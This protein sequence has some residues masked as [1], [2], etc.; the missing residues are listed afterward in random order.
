MTP[1]GDHN[2]SL[3]SVPCLNDDIE[4]NFVSPW[5]DNEDLVEISPLGNQVNEWDGSGRE[6]IKVIALSS[7]RDQ[8]KPSTDRMVGKEKSFRV[9]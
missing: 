4:G 1:L 7:T 6:A 8:E 2:C 3:I 5:D 9:Q